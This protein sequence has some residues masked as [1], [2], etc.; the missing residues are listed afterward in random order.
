VDT[1]PPTEIGPG[2]FVYFPIKM[3]NVANTEDTFRF[4]FLNLEDLTDD[5]WVVA[6]ITDKT[7]QE[8]ETKTITV[9]AQAPQT[10]TI[11]RNDVT[12][13]MLRVTSI[14]SEETAFIVRYDVPL[15]VRQKGIYIP[16]FSPV[17]A[18]LGIGLV[19]LV[20]GKRKMSLG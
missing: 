8:K 7:L 19:A 20:M 1:P 4:E 11:W 18:L 16:G 9:S 17:F 10:W 15:F 6:T 14:Q 2:E 13:L 5:A 3:T 12:P